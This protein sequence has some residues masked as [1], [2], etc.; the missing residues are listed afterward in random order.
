MPLVP[1]TLDDR[2][3]PDLV[4]DLVRRIPAHTPEWTNP[5]LGDPGFTLIELFAWLTDTLLYRANLVPERQR[6][7]FLRLAGVPMR[8]AAA[9]R[10]LV[11]VGFADASTRALQ[12]EPL[13]TLKG[14]VPFETRAELTV[15]PLA[16]QAYV[17]RGLS[18]DEETQKTA[19]LQDLA[20]VYGIRGKPRAYMTMPVFPGGAADPTGFDMVAG[21]VD[22]MLWLALLAAKPELVEDVRA[23]LAAPAEGTQPLLNVGIVPSLELPDELAPVGP[24]QRI[25]HVWEMT[26]VRMPGGREVVEYHALDIVDDTTAGLTQRG[27]L[28]LALPE[29]AFIR[30]PS[31]DPRLVLDAGVGAR[32]PRID[33]PDVAARLVSWLRLRPTTR[34]HSLRLSW[35]GIN[36]VEVDQRQTMT[37]IV[38]GQSDGS[39]DQTFQ[40]PARGVEPESLEIEVDAAET[41]Y[42]AW[43]RV[44]DVATAGRDDPVYELDGEAGSIRFGDGVRGMIPA[45]GRRVRVR[46]MRAGGGRAGNLPPGM[47][48]EVS[49]VERGVGRVRAK[50]A[51]QQSVATIGGEDAES[52]AEAEHRIPAIFQHRDRAI[53]DEDYR[54]IAAE[55][56]GV[57]L[58]RVEVLPRFK[59]QQR[60]S[61]VPGVVTVLVLPQ[62]D[63]TSA[64]APR[65][66]RPLLETVFAHLD[67]RRPLTTELYVVGPEYTPIAV[68]VGVVPR[69]DVGPDEVVYQVREAIRGFL[70]PLLPGG[71]DGVGWPLGG[72]VKNGEIEV[73]VARVAGIS[74]VSDVRLF[75]REVLAP[76]SNGSPPQVRWNQVTP[77]DQG[78]ASIQLRPWQLPEL[79]ALEVSADGVAATQ[80]RAVPTVTGAEK[81]EGEVPVPVIPEVC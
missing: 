32:P 75:T 29:S 8:A 52:L 9:A 57:Q 60:R 47:L 25:P 10:G 55:T 17:K 31:N 69:D 4:E 38:V 79:L 54:R 28:R 12:V 37:A 53:T 50:L 71:D 19:L 16:V 3:F 30:A 11:S 13:A 72:T 41:G 68:S 21:T 77:N 49:A 1:P 22:G 65:P 6:L 39:P 14:P 73:A 62:K 7:A 35:V 43:R 5:R 67:A 34:L 36:V 40:L 26:A 66:D 23:G 20:R 46:T 61:N 45:E 42:V 27:V 78:V 64:P 63:G 18:P 80:I 74:R 51:V 48:K 15:L 59:P 44:D 76:A 56:P 70:W 81:E 58:G 24:R 2:R 33:Q